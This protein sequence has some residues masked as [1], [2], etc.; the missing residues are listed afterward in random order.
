MLD[1]H[2]FLAVY[3]IVLFVFG[4]FNFVMWVQPYSDDD[5][6]HPFLTIIWPIIFVVALLRELVRWWKK[7][8]W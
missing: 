7:Q 6:I 5:P 8:V 4:I 1:F 3:G 2:F